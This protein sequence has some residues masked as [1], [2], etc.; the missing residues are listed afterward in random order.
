M[1]RAASRPPGIRP[2]SFTVD[3]NVTNGQLVQ[4]RV[5]RARLRRQGQERADSIQQMPARVT[6]LSTES[7]S[8]FSGGAY[9]NWTIS[10]NVLI[11]FTNTG[12]CQRRPQRLVLRPDAHPDPDP[13][14]DTRPDPGADRDACRHKHDGETDLGWT[15]W[16]PRDDVAIISLPS[17]A[18]LM[19]SGQSS[20]AQANPAAATRVLDVSRSETTGMAASA[21]ATTSPMVDA[22]TTEKLDE[23][24][25]ALLRRFRLRHRRP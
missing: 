7:V 21:Y 23:Q 6:V 8:N 18:A 3:V 4:P 25:G 17:N 16:C 5:V 24:P 12:P 2:T 1:G 22:G 14:R 15:V 20:V 13:D 11:T 19:P 9:M 10:G